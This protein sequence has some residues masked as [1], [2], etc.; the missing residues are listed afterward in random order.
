MSDWETC[1]SVFLLLAV[2]VS[3]LLAVVFWAL[4]VVRLVVGAPPA[5]RRQTTV[6]QVKPKTPVVTFKNN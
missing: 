6:E 2:G 5:A 3:A 4:L 1:Y